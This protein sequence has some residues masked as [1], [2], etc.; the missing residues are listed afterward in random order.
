MGTIDYI[1]DLNLQRPRWT[2]YVKILSIWNQGIDAFEE[3]TIMILADERANMI[4]AYVPPGNY[5]YNFRSGLKEGQWYY[6]ADFHVVP[7]TRPVKYS[8]NRFALECIWP[9][10][11]WPVG[12]RSNGNFFNFIHSDEVEYAGSEDKDHVSDAIGVICDVSAIQ[13]GRFTTCVA[14]GRNCQ[15]FVTKCQNFQEA[16]DDVQD[17]GMEFERVN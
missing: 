4:D 7:S 15:S 16:E 5:L 13:R 9:T 14:V 17:M 12:P 6:M 3:P 10:T 2:L 1:S 11:M 8:F